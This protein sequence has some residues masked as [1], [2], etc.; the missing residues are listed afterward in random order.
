MGVAKK[1]YDYV[2]EEMKTKGVKTVSVTTGL[3]DAHAPA[4]RAYEKLGFEKVLNSVTYYK[5]I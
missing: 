4:R 5:E 2:I 1:M 3:D